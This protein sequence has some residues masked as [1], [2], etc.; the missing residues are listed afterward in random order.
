[1]KTEAPT[2]SRSLRFFLGLGRGLG[3]LLSLHPANRTPS[4]CCS[5][6]LE[7]NRA[8]CFGKGTRTSGIACCNA[9]G[10]NSSRSCTG[11]RAD[12]ASPSLHLRPERPWPELP[13]RAADSQPS[14]AAAA[15]NLAA[16]DSLV[17]DILAADI[18]RTRTRSEMLPVDCCCL[19]HMPAPPHKAPPTLRPSTFF[20][21]YA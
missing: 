7:C 8:P 14:S 1:M 18:D 2:R 12:R 6:R 9:R 16:A 21:A 3:A 4:P 5:S 17:A 15:G 19:H 10:R 11:A 13:S 20:R